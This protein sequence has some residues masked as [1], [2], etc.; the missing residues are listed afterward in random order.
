[1]GAPKKSLNH[2]VFWPPF[3]LL[4]LA[5][6]LNLALPSTFGQIMT[7]AE[8]WVLDYF[9]WL[10]TLVTV[11]SLV[12]C[13]LVCF[14]PLGRVRL[15]GP[16]A[17]PLMTRWNWFA[18]TLC[19]T[20]AI[21]I[22]F[23]S[24]AEPLSHY[25]QPPA[26]IG[27][28]SESP[29]SFRFAIAALFIHWSFLPYSIY[30]AASLMFGFAYYNMRTHYSLGGTLVPLIGTEQAER[31]GPVIDAVCLYSLVAGMA[32]ALGAGI[33]AI[34]GGLNQLGGVPST[35]ITWLLITLFIVVSFIASSASGLLKGI[36]ILSD[37]NAKALFLLA[38]VVFVVGPTLR[39]LVESF[40]SLGVFAQLLPQLLL[41]EGFFPTETW[42]RDWS[43]FYWAVW[44][45][46]T[47]VTACF[48]G[49]IAYGRTVREFI[50]FNLLIPSL[51]CI[52]WM[53]IFGVTTLHLEQQG[54]D[55]APLVQNDEFEKVSNAVLAILPLGSLMV[56]YYLLSAF[57]CYVTSADSNTTAMASLSEKGITQEDSE[58]DTKIKFV[59][60]VMV[61]ATAWTIISYAGGVDGVRT[62]SDLGGLPAAFLLLLVLAA[63][64]KVAWN[65]EKYD[66]TAKLQV[67]IQD[68]E[69]SPPV[70]D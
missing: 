37:I 39:I 11:L 54:A 25:Y 61:G 14:L 41:V 17:Q 1:M 3:L 50:L 26:S 36:R 28:P 20:V 15:G 66:Q 55:L 22:L 9:G 23:W 58:G 38:G 62:L 32:A 59:W 46:W 7:T 24:T 34:A 8:K 35:P 21:G 6:I 2:L 47:P 30:C 67:P 16:Q 10:F 56:G 63:L 69:G 31:I 12:V 44:I 57:V 48:L 49:R 29:E 45:A 52:A 70:A 18:I 64:V 53:G 13:L 42:V 19:T 68:R 51:F 4:L 27:I 43:I 40:Y 5:V 65:P 33:L 60:G